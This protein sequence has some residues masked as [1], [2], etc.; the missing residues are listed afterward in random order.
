MSFQ[1]GSIDKNGLARTED[2][3][4]YVTSV[5]TAAITGTAST[6]FP[7][8]LA[9]SF[10]AVSGANDTNENVLATI[11]V[12]ANTLG[13]NGRLIIETWWSVNNTVDAK[14][15]RV[16]FNGAAGTQY[17]SVSLASTVGFHA[18]T[19]I[20]AAN[21]TSAQFGFSN[22]GGQAG[23]WGTSSNAVI[24]GAVDTTAATSIVLS[25]QKATG[26]DTMTLRGYE[27]WYVKASNS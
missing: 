8:L 4:L 12:A 9:Q 19:T 26:T 13:S 7:V 17:L 21:S 15:V 6:G 1:T 16:R 25:T 22:N 27:V 24:T 5:G 11:N 23:G 18:T 20:A 2:G 10:A 3:K 14:T